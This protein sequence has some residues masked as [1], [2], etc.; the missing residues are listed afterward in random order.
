MNPSPTG[1]KKIRKPMPLIDKV[2]MGPFEKYYK[3]DRFPFKMCI[4]F[5]LALVITGQIFLIVNSNADYSI[6]I[7]RKLFTLFFDEEMELEGVDKMRERYFFSAIDVRTQVNWIVDNYF[8][9]PDMDSVE[10]YELVEKIDEEGNKVINPV[11]MSPYF[12]RKEDR[13]PW[14]HLSINFTETDRGGF[15]VDEEGE[16]ELSQKD[17]RNFLSAMSNFQL[18]FYI[19]HNIPT[20]KFTTFDCYRW[21]VTINFDV[22]NNGHYAQTLRMDRQFC[23]DIP[24]GEISTNFLTRYLWVL[25]LSSLLSVL[26]LY[27][28][29]KYIKDIT[30]SVERVRKELSKENA[31]TIRRV[32]TSYDINNKN[33]LD[34]SIPNIRHSEKDEEED[35][36]EQESDDED[37]T[38]NWSDFSVKDKWELFSGWSV[39]VIAGNILTLVASV[40]LLTSTK[41]SQRDGEIL[42]GF[43]GFLVVASLMKYYENVKGYNIILNTMIKSVF[44]FMKAIIGSLPIFLGFAVLGN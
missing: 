26:N 28:N 2:C 23:V 11:M 16:G 38:F 8:N 17:L 39:I 42:L 36:N 43:G 5:L 19:R 24:A 27:L 12:L 22:I 41:T 40:Y 37:N 31:K 15:T 35:G 3:Y 13:V 44:V 32:N 14:N 34:R 9:I 29:V 1:R 25:V 30:S 20:V 21:I 7:Q 10:K 6:S 33:F 18:Q 4:H